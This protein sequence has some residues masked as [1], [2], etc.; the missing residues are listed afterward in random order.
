MPKLVALNLTREEYERLKKLNGSQIVLAK[1]VEINDASKDA[2]V[3]AETS[4]NDSETATF[5][6]LFSAAEPLDYFL[7]MLGTLGG[8]G[9]GLSFPF[10]NVIFGESEYL[11][12]SVF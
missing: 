5:A 2:P 4:L 8:I 1:A 3:T 10:F 6:E 12:V 7:M 11:F 9:T